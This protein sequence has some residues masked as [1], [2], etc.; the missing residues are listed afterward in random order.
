MKRKVK[1]FLILFIFIEKKNSKKDKKEAKDSKKPTADIV[2]KETE[3]LIKNQYIPLINPV[4]NIEKVKEISPQPP[5]KQ[6]KPK[7]N[8]KP[9]EAK[10]EPIIPQ[11]SKKK[12]KNKNDKTEP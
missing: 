7:E 12:K 10:N 9:V 1:S 11:D 5:T 6:E 4:Q 3:A 2:K 8:T